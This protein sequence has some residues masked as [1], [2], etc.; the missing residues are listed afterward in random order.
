MQEF[1]YNISI[2]S[3]ARVDY[4][5][6]VDSIIKNISACG[7]DRSNGSLSSILQFITI[8]EVIFL[9]SLLQLLSPLKNLRTLSD[10]QS[11]QG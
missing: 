4:H 11:A 9:V 2:L 8:Q 6:V 1:H 3:W 10:V 7:R 5:V